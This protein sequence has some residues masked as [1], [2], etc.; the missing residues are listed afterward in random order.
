MIIQVKNVNKKFVMCLILETIIILTLAYCSIGSGQTKEPIT[1]GFL[2]LFT[3]ILL[4]YFT[5]SEWLCAS[6]IITMNESGCEVQIFKSHRRF[7]WNEF[8][9]VRM[10]YFRIN[11]RQSKT[12]IIF[13]T[14]KIGSMYRKYPTYLSLIRPHFG[15]FYVMFPYDSEKYMIP[16]EEYGAFEVNEEEFMSK[17]HEWGVRIENGLPKHKR[18]KYHSDWL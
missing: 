14:D 15:Y 5:I 13:C 9:T 3:Y 11:K 2:L 17:M 10:E 7:T 16:S 1:F 18:L 4:I 6:K 12:G 8:K